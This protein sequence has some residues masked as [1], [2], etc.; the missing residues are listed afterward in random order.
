[1]I[2]Y[3]ATTNPGK[4]AEFRMAASDTI[5]IEPLP[6]L[7]GIPPCDE[8][9]STFEANAVEKALYYGAH[10]KGWLFAEDSGLE[11]EAL[12]GEPGVYSARFA[13]ANATDDAN[14]RLVLERLAGSTQRTARYVCVIALVHDGSLVQTFRGDV[15]G[16]ILTGA[17]RHPR[18][19]IR[20]VV[21]L[22]SIRLFLW[23]GRSGTETSCE[24]SRQGSRT[25]DHYT[26]SENPKA[27]F[28]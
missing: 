19:R 26:W 14:N 6:G 25:T 7:S 16:E 20:P 8:T 22:P 23:R 3:C 12:N 10:T 9:G 17:S 18:F 21:L 24:S 11:V 15:E 27:A 28:P 1:M 13:G 2:V 4:I 5:H